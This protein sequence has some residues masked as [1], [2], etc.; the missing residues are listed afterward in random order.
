M[1]PLNDV[2][3]QAKDFK[4]DRDVPEPITALPPDHRIIKSAPVSINEPPAFSHFLPE[5]KKLIRA[6]GYDPDA[7]YAPHGTGRKPVWVT[8]YQKLY[9]ATGLFK[10]NG[11]PNQVETY[12]V[13]NTIFEMCPHCQKK[14]LAFWIDRFHLE[15]G[16]YCDTCHID[17]RTN[18]TL[19][20][21]LQRKLSNSYTSTFDGFIGNDPFWKEIPL[22]EPGRHTHLGAAMA[23][24]KTTF[25][26]GTG[27]EIATSEDKFFV[28]CVPRISLALNIASKLN[29]QYGEKAFG[30]YYESSRYKY[31][32]S[33]GAVCTLTSLPLLF[34]GKEP[35]DPK[36][37]L[38]FI[39]EVDFSYPLTELVTPQARKVKT[40]LRQALHANGL[41]TA[42]QTEYTAVVE[43]FAEEMETDAVS[44]YY[45]TAPA[46]E[47]QVQWIEYPDIDG[48][49]IQALAGI[50]ESIQ[51][52]LA[53]GQIVY[54]F[55]SERRQ[56]DV[57]A[58]M[59]ESENPLV[60]S[61]LTKHQERNK[62]LLHDRKLTDTNLLIATSAADVGI[63]IEDDRDSRTLVLPTLLYGRVPIESATQETARARG[64]QH[65]EMHVPIYE[66]ALPLKPTETKNVFQK[67]LAL[68]REI[69]AIEA[70]DF[71]T[72][73]RIATKKAT[74]LT[75]R[76][77]AEQQPLTF[78]EH[79]LHRIAG[80]HIHVVS[81]PPA[82]QK[83][84]LDEIRGVKKEA[85]SIEKEKRQEYAKKV[86]TAEIERL[87]ELKANPTKYLPASLKSATEI[88]Q[89]AAD[90]Y[91]TSFNLLGQRY[92]NELAVAIGFDDL[93]DWIRSGDP[94]DPQPF[95][96][97]DADLPCIQNMVNAGI[98]ATRLTNQM[99]GYIASRDRDW[100]QQHTE[101]KLLDL[102][103]TAVKDYRGIGTLARMLC[104]KLQ[105]DSWE[106]RDFATEI[107]DTLHIETHTSTVLSDIKNG[108]LGDTI[109]K[110]ARFLFKIEDATLPDP[111][112]L[113][114]YADFAIYVVETYL[115]VQIRRQTL[116]KRGGVEKHTHFTLIDSN[117]IDVFQ[118]A[119]NCYLAHNVRPSREAK[120]HTVDRIG[121][122]ETEKQKRQT[123]AVKMKKDGKTRKE[124]A[125]ATGLS[126]GSVSNAT[127]SVNPTKNRNADQIAKAKQ[128]YDNGNGKSYREIGRILNKAPNTIKKWCLM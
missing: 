78:V 75:L 10:L 49:E 74:T 124:I 46:H 14:T 115:P 25:V 56:A 72:E 43:A 32:G 59:F 51:E 50:A 103:W 65:I 68:K 2:I 71:L 18:S 42:G 97:N 24:G 16:T 95:D 36:D 70:D 94:K 40:A 113:Q 11:Q 120:Y 79:H 4:G 33:I 47:G 122:P 29:R 57:L 15:A 35:L 102:E 9:D 123:E 100:I 80:Y 73:S 116:K 58:K 28:I 48:K 44:G 23:L 96:W 5:D 37:C 77:L 108:D 84:K 88:R 110:K 99:H 90:G 92:V 101:T 106:E 17:I 1:K 119:L 105:G 86:I 76:D 21:E 6:C 81:D 45:K 118:Q 117:A 66:S 89:S 60:Y 3:K 114:R 112:V 63:S 87:S 22:W 61:S 82:A 12:R 64:T 85:L 20:L 54:A 121:M 62:K 39:D 27:C 41:V 104:E 8:Q 53:A 30:I 127:K 55:T 109:Y 34:Q 13:W 38:I 7:S 31:L 69:A 26:Q 19:N 98:D 107:H 125:D 91:I 111:Q 126:V 67:S 52:G 128:L 93:P 83:S